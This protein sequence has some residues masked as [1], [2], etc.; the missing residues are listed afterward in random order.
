MD[1]EVVVKFC[2]LQAAGRR[3][4]DHG[5]T[6]RRLQDLCSGIKAVSYRTPKGDQSVFASLCD[7]TCVLQNTA[8]LVIAANH[9]S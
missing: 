6:S 9:K 7:V 5:L 4:L 8:T 3:E 2:E 1:D